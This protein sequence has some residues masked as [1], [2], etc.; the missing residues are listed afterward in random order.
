MLCYLLPLAFLAACTN[1]P[2][3]P[4]EPVITYEGVNKAEIF[5]YTNGPLDSI[6][7]HFSFTDGDGNLSNADSVDVFLTDSRFGIASPRNIPLFPSE[8]TGNGISGDIFIAVQN[9]ANGICCISDTRF[10]FADPNFPIDTF[11]YAIQIRDRANNFSNLIRTEV[12]N[13]KCLGQ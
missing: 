6:I 5:Q 1:A 10:C 8:G 11:S 3:F 13:I 9:L 4:A 7:I 2:D 12:I